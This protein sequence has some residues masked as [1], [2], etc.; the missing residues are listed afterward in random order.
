MTDPVRQWFAEQKHRGYT[1]PDP[2]AGRGPVPLT[3]AAPS[4]PDLEAL[5]PGAGRSRPPETADEAFVRWLRESRD[6]VHGSI[7]AY[8]HGDG[9]INR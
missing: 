3:R 7:S 6:G 9:V 1:L 5:T 8:T 4:R 2:P